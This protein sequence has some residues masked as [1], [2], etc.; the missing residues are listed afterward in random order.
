LFP[1]QCHASE[2]CQR[3]SEVASVAL[4]NLREL[5]GRD[6]RIKGAELPYS[7]YICLADSRR[8]TVI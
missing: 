3:T 5:F 6:E 1:Y 2:S 7:D 4:F 8:A